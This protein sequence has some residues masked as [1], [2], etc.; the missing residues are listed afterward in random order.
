MA[1]LDLGTL[2]IVL[3]ADRHRGAPGLFS[4]VLATITSTLQ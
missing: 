1:M 3:W 4:L 2:M